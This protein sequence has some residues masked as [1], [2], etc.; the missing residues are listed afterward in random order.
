MQSDTSSNKIE[1]QA[2]AG[3][4]VK[5]ADG[6]PFLGVLNKPTAEPTTE[7]TS[8][9]LS[10][11]LSVADFGNDK[12][13]PVYFKD[14]NDNPINVTIRIPV[15]NGQIGQIVK[16]FYSHDGTTWTPHETTTT[17]LKRFGGKIYAQFDTN[18]ETIFAIGTDTGSFVIN[19]DS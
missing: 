12:S 17:T 18:H 14:I 2:P 16:I 1:V 9:G 8:H 3:L 5:K 13:T 15:P 19:N 4:V 6:S 11:I 10:N 7:A